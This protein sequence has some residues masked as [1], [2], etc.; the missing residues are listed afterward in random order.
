MCT[1][2]LK[3]PSSYVHGVPYHVTYPVMHLISST[4]IPEQSDGQLPV[5]TLSSR[6]L[7]D[8]SNRAP[9]TLE[10]RAYALILKMK[11]LHKSQ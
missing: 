2:H 4:R 8:I 3:T 6:N 1:T 10:D 9:R 5:K 7:Q 11:N